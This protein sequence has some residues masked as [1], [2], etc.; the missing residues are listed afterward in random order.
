MVAADLTEQPGVALDATAGFLD[1]PTPPARRLGARLA[2]AY[3][4][5]WSVVLAM[6]LACAV[7]PAARRLAHV[8][9]GLALRARLH[10]PPAPSAAGALSLLANN[11]RA[12]GW[13]LLPCALDAGRY[14]VLRRLV[15][16]TV[17]LGV[18]VNLLPVG[19]ALG[20][21]RVRLLPYLPQLPF[22]L[23]G[24]TSAAAGWRAS[25]RRLH[26]RELAAAAASVLI[27]LILAA[28]L[29]TWAVP[30]GP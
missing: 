13:P 8:A 10:P 15:D 16:V 9:F 4:A 2:I 7:L 11:A 23:Y 19:A 28:V 20:V 24:V 1:T 5:G 6:A 21:Y 26:R 12:A 27:A 22:E 14:P 3:A 25:R 29:E 18:A 30:H 17:L